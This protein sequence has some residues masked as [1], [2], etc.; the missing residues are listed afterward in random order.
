MKT[1]RAIRTTTG[2]LAAIAIVL[3]AA[4]CSGAGPELS[5]SPTPTFASSPA[6]TRTAAPS[7]TA[8]ANPT[9]SPSSGP[10]VTALTAGTQTALVMGSGSYPGYTVLVPPGWF[11]QGD[12]FTIKYPITG[13]PGPVLG[14]SVWD[15][16]QVFRD[17]CHWEGQG[18]DPGPGVDNLVAALVAQKM[19]NASKPTDVTLA[20]YKGKYLEL[21]VPAGMKSTTWTDFDGCDT[22][23]AG[24]ATF[25]S[26]LG[27]GLGARYEVVAG[28]V[29]RVWVLDV[30]GQRLVVDA[31]YSPDTSQA[32]RAQLEQ[33]V[34]SLRFDAP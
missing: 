32:D 8:P 10:A 3:V 21:S 28:Q 31:T 18:F 11:D 14:L 27:N 29:D 24:N 16:G 5:S 17:P 15:V 25:F 7:V 22:D 26:W 19:R 34:D 1:G 6:S 12:R 33:V 9:Q 23:D 30:R 13:T 20:G 2:G 4:A